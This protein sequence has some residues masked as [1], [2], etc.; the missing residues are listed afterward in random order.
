MRINRQIFRRAC[1]YIRATVA[2]EEEK[3]REWIE[4]AAMQN[5]WLELPADV[6]PQ[7][8]HLIANSMATNVG[9][10]GGSNTQRKK[11]L[12]R[13]MRELDLVEWEGGLRSA[14]WVI[15]YTLLASSGHI[16]EDSR[17]WPDMPTFSISPECKQAW[18]D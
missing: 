17:A 15:I 11:L 6:A 12:R 10:V 5:R 14:R 9:L 7:R 16:K 18:P 3:W 1:E 8:F 13:I 4:S 2:T